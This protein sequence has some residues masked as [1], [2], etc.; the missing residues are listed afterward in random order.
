MHC[1]S[2]IVNAVVLFLGLAV[3]DPEMEGMGGIDLTGIESV[4]T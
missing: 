1:P 4:K 3:F 2:R